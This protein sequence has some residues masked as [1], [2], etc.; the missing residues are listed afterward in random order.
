MLVT[1]SKKKGT[2]LKNVLFGIQTLDTFLDTVFG[3]FFAYSFL[4]AMSFV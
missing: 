1:P 3:Y 4:K 2:K